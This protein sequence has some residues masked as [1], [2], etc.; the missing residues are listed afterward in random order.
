MAVLD[1]YSASVARFPISVGSDLK[2]NSAAFS[3]VRRTVPVGHPSETG[4]KCPFPDRNQQF[5]PKAILKLS[6]RSTVLKYHYRLPIYVL[7]RGDAVRDRGTPRLYRT[8][9]G[10]PATNSG[11]GE[12]G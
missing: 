5:L 3:F 4:R 8:G 11:P 1:A 12:D 6:V 7:E 10:G 2:V 9:L